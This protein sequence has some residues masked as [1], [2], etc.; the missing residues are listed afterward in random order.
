MMMKQLWF[1]PF[2]GHSVLLHIN[3][4]YQHDINQP[5]PAPIYPTFT[6]ALAPYYL[7]TSGPSGP[8]KDVSTQ[9]I[10]CQF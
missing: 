8:A 9:I 7:I 3:H 4:Q 6:L 5:T 2:R 10:I 1:V